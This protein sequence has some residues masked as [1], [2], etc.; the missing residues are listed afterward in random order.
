VINE[1][2]AGLLQGYLPD[3]AIAFVTSALGAAGITAF[4][5]TSDVLAVWI[6]RKLIGRFQ[7]RYG[8]NRVGPFGLL[9]P[10]A[11]AVKILGKEAVTPFGVDRWVYWAAPTIAFLPGLLTFAV[12][13]FA[14]GAVLADLDVGL[15][16]VM[17]VGA[18]GVVPI[19]MAGWASNN[20]YSLLGAMR[21]V[22]QTVSYE[23][24]LVLSIIGLVLFAN[25]LRLSDIVAY[26]LEHGWFIFLQP[27]AFIIF[28]IAG[29]AELNRTP[30][31]IMEGESEIVGGY[32]TEYSGFKFSLFYVSEY[33]HIFG[34][35]ALI[36]SLF[37]GGWG[38]GPVLDV[39]PGIVWFVIKVYLMFCVFVWVRGTLPRLRIDQLMDFAWKF[40][41]PLTLV[42]IGIA[43]VEVYLELP[44]LVVFVVN[45]LFAGVL[46]VGWTELLRGLGGRARGATRA[47]ISGAIAHGSTGSP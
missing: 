22:A 43:G 1:F 26:Q 14:P 37:L 33:T 18:L 41:I 30:T 13:P 39:V 28:F 20:K 10:V 23:I 40:L 17:A 44:S 8:P 35:S 36:V 9:Q 31:D 38:T 11:D 46:I 12:V 19:F 32:H 25:S 45:T 42:N 5:V 15:L 4:V 47:G 7:V 6:E 24:P 21:A 16:Y 29:S 2:V 3:W 27:L 34:V